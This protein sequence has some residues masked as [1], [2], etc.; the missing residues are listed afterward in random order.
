[1]RVPHSKKWGGTSGARNTMKTNSVPHCPTAPL[2][3]RN[4]RG[5]HVVWWSALLSL[6]YWSRKILKE[7]FAGPLGP[8]SGITEKQWGR[9]GSGARTLD[10]AG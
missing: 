2:K 3:K 4:Y 7:I 10:T 9:W 1:M 5:R 6:F 8:L